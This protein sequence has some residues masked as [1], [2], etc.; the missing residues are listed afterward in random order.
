MTFPR[1]D[2]VH[3]TNLIPG[4]YENLRAAPKLVKPHLGE[5]LE[6][7]DS[8]SLTRASLQ[9]YLEARAVTAFQL[10]A[11]FLAR[12]EIDPLS[13]QLRLY[14]PAVGGLPSVAAYDRLALAEVSS[15]SEDRYRLTVDAGGMHYTAY[16]LFEQIVAQMELGASF[17]IAFL[18][19]VASMKNIL[20]GPRVLTDEQVTGLWGE[21][22]VLRRVIRSQ[23]ASS[24]LEAWLGPRGEEH[25]FSFASFE[26]EVKTTRSEKRVHKIA[27]AT[28]LQPSPGRPLMLFS[29]QVTRAGAG[30]GGATLPALASE[31]REL[32]QGHEADFDLLMESI[33]YRDDD[34]EHY[35]TALQPRTAPCLYEVGPA[36]PA[37]KSDDLSRTVPSFH[38]VQQLEYTIDV[39][40]IAAVPLMPPLENE[41]D[42]NV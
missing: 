24:A 22:F 10:G 18:A 3:E 7:L 36:F 17:K 16:Q 34:A 31:L 5:A 2:H 40:G 25:D 35:S 6:R 38:L 1:L 23:G 42:E 29:L 28:Q 4:N 13:D 12:L 20:A 30:E 11:S 9:S 27:S 21:L 26:L 37:L 15:E 41:E 32:L 39:S 33:G 14:V 8:K 19:S